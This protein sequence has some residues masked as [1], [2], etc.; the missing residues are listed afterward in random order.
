MFL[1]LLAGGKRIGVTANSHKVI[2]NLLDAVC[3]AAD[4]PPVEVR[5]IQKANAGDGCPD[6]RIVQAGSNAEVAEALAG[7]ANLAAG[8]AWLW[9]REEMAGAVDVLVIDEA[10]QMSLANTLA[11]CQAAG[12]LVLL[13]DPRQLDQP[14]QGVHPP[15][16]DVSALG[17]LLG[18]SATVDP[19]RGV[20]LDQ[21]W[22]MHPDICAFTTEQF[23]EG[24]LRPQPELGRQTV[25]G[26]GPLA[27]HG[28]RFIPVEHAGNTNASAE[29]ADCVAALIRE[30]LDAGAAWVDREGVREPLTLQDVLVVAPYNAHVA[31]LRS[32]L[33][34]GARVGTV[35]K[36][37]G[38]EAPIVIYSMATSTADE[39]P[40]GM[41]F[42]YS[43]HRLN[44]ATSRAR[45]VAAI[46]ANSALLT[47][48]CRTPEQMRL[49]T[50]P[51]AAAP[52]AGRARPRTRVPELTIDGSRVIR[53][54]VR[55]PSGTRLPRVR[56]AGLYW[57]GWRYIEA[58][59]QLMLARRAV[60]RDG[61]AQR[62]RQCVR[63]HTKGHA[64]PRWTARIW[65]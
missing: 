4:G 6:E 12:S 56:E 13:G 14:I 44:V 2:S 39:A 47:P 23:Y 29:E 58:L 63:A 65:R 43:L 28:L 16:A 22:R 20:F 62:H 11:V 48:D 5:G 60:H 61:W 7:D 18:E 1:D 17:H 57:T 36:F 64:G 51:S 26:P 37:Q 49:A 35:D 55:V 52:R 15:G 54:K 9:A 19:S 8:T 32:T 46:V 59:R 41:E 24:R 21:T 3:E 50:I 38:Q 33:P 27:G 53:P 42:L 45:C 25:A 34:A 40:R 31:V 30:L 10:A